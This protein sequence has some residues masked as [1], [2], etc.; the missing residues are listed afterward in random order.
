LEG[1]GN[2]Y[3]SGQYTVLGPE[4]TISW[5]AG[6]PYAFIQ[7]FGGIIH[8]P[9]SEG[10]LQVFEIDGTIVFTR[11]TKPHDIPIPPR[12]YMMFQNE[13]IDYIMGLF[14]H[15]AIEFEGT[16]ESIGVN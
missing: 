7:N 12:A 10:K 11:K 8:H 4:V 16:S 1:T 6:L 2:L 15:Y 3:A 9:G 14:A 5:G 13:D